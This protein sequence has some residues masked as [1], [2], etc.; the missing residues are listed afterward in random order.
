[1]R[2]KGPYKHHVRKHTR[3]D[4]DNK[5]YA[6]TDYERGKGRQ[7][8]QTPFIKRTRVTANKITG[9]R[10]GSGAYDVHLTYYD[11]G[12]EQLKV[13]ADNYHGATIAGEQERLSPR[14]IRVMSMRRG[15]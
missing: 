14:P 9:K 10:G 12:T 8:T 1:M 15:K 4:R 7:P 2:R 5:P 6:V 13:D 11:A 3:K